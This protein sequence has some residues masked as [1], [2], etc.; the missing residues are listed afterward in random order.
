LGIGNDETYLTIKLIYTAKTI[1]FVMLTTSAALDPEHA[2][3]LSI[4]FC[5]P[6]ALFA[7]LKRF[8]DLKNLLA[9]PLQNYKVKHEIFVVT[10]HEQDQF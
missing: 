6:L 2:R 4:H 3:N 5:L 1:G 7:K 8:I 9:Q 10:Q